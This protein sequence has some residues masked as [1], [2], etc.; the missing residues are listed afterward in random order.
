M[1][2]DNHKTL[3]ECDP[4][5]YKGF[6]EWRIVLGRIR[7]LSSA[8]TYW[9]VHSMFYAREVHEKMKDA[10]LLELRN[11]SCGSQACTRRC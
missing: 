1:G 4:A 6:I 3:E 11:V 2:Y 5:V 10:V 9:K 7:K 8:T